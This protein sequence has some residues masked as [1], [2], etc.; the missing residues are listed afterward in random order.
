MDKNDNE[1]NK[2]IHKVFTK[3]IDKLMQT[4]LMEIGINQK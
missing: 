3:M 4:L 1:D 2:R